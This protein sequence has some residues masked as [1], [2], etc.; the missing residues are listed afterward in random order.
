MAYVTVSR[1][2]SHNLASVFNRRVDRRPPVVDARR[3]GIRALRDHFPRFGRRV[4]RLLARFPRPP[5][6]I[7]PR[8]APVAGAHSRATAAPLAAPSRNIMNAVPLVD[9]SSYDI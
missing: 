3:D 8:V 6:E 1:P 7:F 4:R 5:L 2:C 9:L